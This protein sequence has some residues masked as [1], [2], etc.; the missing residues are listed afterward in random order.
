MCITI[1]LSIYVRILLIFSIHDYGY[2]AYVNMYYESNIPIY[3]FPE[4]RFEDRFASEE[5]LNL[6]PYI[7]VFFVCKLPKY[8]AT[9]TVDQKYTSRQVDI[10]NSLKRCINKIKSFPTSYLCVYY[11]FELY[12]YVC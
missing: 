12:I 10:K 7:H 1:I 8:N 2:D 5:I 11:F 6:F 3:Y 4:V 9:F